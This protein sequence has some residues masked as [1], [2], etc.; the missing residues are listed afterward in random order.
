MGYMQLRGGG[1]AT[2][3]DDGG[4][5]SIASAMLMFKTNPNFIWLKP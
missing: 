1:V 4:P 2:A 5:E 3:R